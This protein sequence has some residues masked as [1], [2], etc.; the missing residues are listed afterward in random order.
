MEIYIFQ[1]YLT[2]R[3]HI[4]ASPLETNISKFQMFQSQRRKFVQ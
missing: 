1:T 3:E 2:Y 4:P